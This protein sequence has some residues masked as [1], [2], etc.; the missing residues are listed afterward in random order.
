MSRAELK[1]SDMQAEI[2]LGAR[3]CSQLKN[4]YQPNAEWVK[5]NRAV[6]AKLSALK[7]ITRK[8]YS[9]LNEVQFLQQLTKYRK[10]EFE[11][12]FSSG[13]T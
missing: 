2:N 6:A 11:D 10:P 5:C 8:Y 12:A 1:R 7:A 13:Q 4:I 9:G 3:I